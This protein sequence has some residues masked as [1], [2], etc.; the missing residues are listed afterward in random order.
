MFIKFFSSK[1][2]FTT[3]YTIT[4]LFIVLTIFMFKTN[5]IS[6]PVLILMGSVFGAFV[7]GNV[8]GDHYG[9]T[10]SI[11]DKVENK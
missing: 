3:V 6:E 1:K 2:F 8:I 10:V 4:L 5:T 11:V 7:T 9:K